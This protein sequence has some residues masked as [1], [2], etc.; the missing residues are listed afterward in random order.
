[1]Q[2]I[3]AVML[4]LTDLRP[5][6]GGETVFPRLSAPGQGGLTVLPGRAGTAIVWPTVD[7]SGVPTQTAARTARPLLED[8]VKYVAMTW[9]RTGAAPG[10]P[11]GPPA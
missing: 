10:E 4:Q 2:R 9:V 8:E 1:G 11:G 6:S 5:G 3:A 7:A